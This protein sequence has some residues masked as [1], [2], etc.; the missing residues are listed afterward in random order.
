MVKEKTDI[1]REAV[2]EFPN[3]YILI[4]ELQHALLAL[5]MN[6]GGEDGESILK[7]SSSGLAYGR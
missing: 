5:G 2:N 7:E 1:M 3:N 6:Y 4:L